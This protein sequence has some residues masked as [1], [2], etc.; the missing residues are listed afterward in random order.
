MLLVIDG[1]PQWSFVAKRGALTGGFD[2]LLREGEWHTGRFPTPA[3]TSAP[4]HAVLGTGEPPAASGIVSN[5]WWDREAGKIVTAVSDGDGETASAAHLQVPG[6]ADAIARAKRGGKAVGISLLARGAILPLGHAGTPIWYDAKQVAFTSTR[7]V[8]WLAAY[9]REHPISKHLR[10]VWNPLD[11]G[12]IAKLSGVTDAR[13]G[14]IGTRGFGP[15][16]PHALGKTKAPASAV[17][18]TPLGNQ[19]VLDLAVAAI[20][21]EHLGA[22]AT[23]DL[24]VISLSANNDIAHGWGHE[25]WEAWDEL[26]RLD[27]QLGELLRVLDDKLG[28]GAWSMIATADH[29]G[30]PLPD[31]DNRD[32]SR[33]RDGR[34]GGRITFEQLE[35]AV[36]HAAATELGGGDWVTLVTYPGGIYLTD[37]ARESRAFDTATKKM[38]FALRSFPGIEHVERTVDYAGH[39]DARTGY[40]FRLCQMLDPERSGDVIVIPRR[41][42]ILEH[43][44]KPLATG[45]GSDHDYDTD[46]PVIV[47][48][49]RRA[50]HPALSHPSDT[51]V[52]MIR[53]STI[54]AR[55]LGVTPP[56]SIPRPPPPPPPPPPE[57]TE[58]R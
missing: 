26:L 37:K 50:S 15:T 47:V 31:P 10:D 11:R 42:W 21:A 54:L 2:R 1:L 46:V 24:L 57:S 22:D 41:G 5:E 9:N 27:T 7:S 25:S 35:R 33:N 39:C 3:T 49:P 6:L 13:A 8:P 55:W 19:L 53:I 38:V 12:R 17:F 4:G 40:A 36:D 51:T 20:D 56:V 14:E 28:A 45:N 43:R 18:A 16:F 32:S 23:P 48:P 52:R 30:A 58:S 34:T 44:A 29:G